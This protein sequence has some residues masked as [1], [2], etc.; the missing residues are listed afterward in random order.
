[1]TF[2]HSIA[3]AAATVI[4]SPPPGAGAGT[5]MNLALSASPAGHPQ[6]RGVLYSAGFALLFT[7]TGTP[8]AIKIL[9]RLGVGQQVRTDG[10]QAHLAKRGIPTMGGIVIVLATLLAYVATK[11]V[12]GQGPSASAVLV[13]LL[14]TAM[15]VVG[16]VDDLLK[17]FRGR[18]LGLRARAK[19]VGQWAA[20]IV[21][22]VA[23]LHFP[24]SHGYH[25]ASA[26]ISFYRDTALTIGPILF[27]LWA[28]F[29]IAGASNGV[30]LTDGADGLA[31]GACTMVFGAYVFI[32]V[33]QHGQS[34]AALGPAGPPA[35]CYQVRDPLDLAVV[36]AAIMGS[37]FAFLWWN[38]APVQIFL[39]D[40]GSLALGGA[41]AGLAICT[42]T[43]LLLA[44]I[45][46]LFVMNTVS[47]VLQVASFRYRGGKRIF[48]IA[49]LHHHFEV[50]GWS[51]TTVVVRF[52]ILCGLFVIAGIT[53]FYAGWSTVQ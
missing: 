35:G 11:L 47:V 9:T 10:V 23:A 31:A 26:H 6:M 16:G 5:S 52:W 8:A 44:L 2:P 37:C 12:T 22:A 29:L 20:A 48:K 14:M 17:V 13:L 34:C 15:G 46:G 43:E 38:T 51:E 50:I 42:R 33:W 3:A 4:G 30:N 19:F 7:F 27:V 49:P 39:G 41:L 24:N 32:G 1:M 53:V 36:A 25:P 18:S 45:G 21:F 40:V 28:G